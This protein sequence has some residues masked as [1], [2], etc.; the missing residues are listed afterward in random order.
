M[1]YF[2]VLSFLS[3]LCNKRGLYYVNYSTK[4]PVVKTTF[5]ALGTLIQDNKNEMKNEKN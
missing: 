1:F 3:R 2:E 5:E 4:L